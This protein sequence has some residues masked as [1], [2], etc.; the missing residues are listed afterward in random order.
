MPDKEITGK[1]TTP[2]LDFIFVMIAV[3]LAIFVK[4]WES[5]LGV[6]SATYGAIA[7][8]LVHDNQWFHLHMQPKSYDPF[9]DQPYLVLWLDAILFKLLGASAQ[10]IR[11][12]SSVAG[13]FTF[14][15]NG[16]AIGI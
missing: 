14:A 11:L 4:F 2:N 1:A 6:S 7:N 5:G 10:T 3:F 9:V 16:D 12:L 15:G 8:N 13:F